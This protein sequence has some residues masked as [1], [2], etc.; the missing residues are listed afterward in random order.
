MTL[1]LVEGQEFAARYSL[2]QRLS[3][4][5]HMESWLALDTEL[6]ERVVLRVFNDPLDEPVRN[7]IQEAINA[8]RGLVHP[9]ITRLYGIESDGKH[10]FIAAEF[11]G[12]ASPFEP[13]PD[14]LRQQWPLLEQLFDAIN[15]AH[16]LGLAHGHLH[17]GKLLVDENN[18]LHITDFGLPLLIKSD[19]D[20]A[21]WLSPQARRG[22]TPDSSDDVY[23]VGQLLFVLLTGRQ[24]RDN[25]NFESSSPI[26]LEVQEAVAAMLQETAWERPTDLSTVVDA[27]RDYLVEGSEPSFDDL[28]TFIRPRNTE[29][30]I[31]NRQAAATRASGSHRP[32]RERNAV[33]ASLAYMGLSILVLIALIVFFALPELEPD[34]PSGTSVQTVPVPGTIPPAAKS[35]A[36]IRPVMTPYEIAKKENLEKEGTRVAS[37]I[38]RLQVELEDLGVRLW[39]GEA[40][41]QAVD[42]TTTA[43]VAYRQGE[44]EQAIAIYHEVLRQLTELKDRAGEV[45]ARNLELGST[46]ITDGDVAAAIRAYTIAIAIDPDDHAKAQLE[47]AEGLENVMALVEAG[48]FHEA[49][50]QLDVAKDKLE[51]AVE[52]DSQWRPAQEALARVEDKIATNRFNDAMS[53][54]LAALTDSEYEVARTE[55]ERARD[56]I[57]GSTE[58]ADGLEQIEVRLKQ[59]AVDERLESAAE[60]V[61]TE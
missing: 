53:R 22:E 52:L 46:A 21:S 36:D 48:I 24:W 40:F 7:R 45:L 8:T 18:V 55:F 28:A 50:G 5:Q 49:E 27:L 17:P 11:I 20:R 59:Q 61:R 2:L 47:R 39:A 38:L 13:Q 26:P 42:L 25:D 1:Q 14:S 9:N 19:D 10:D 6:R 44:F 34:S 56:I 23:S 58:P 3:Q 35:E 51:Q 41:E 16:S 43:D 33:P 12:S 32:A 29:S 30:K 15:F 54:A 4:R 31:D 37:E 60:H 57:P